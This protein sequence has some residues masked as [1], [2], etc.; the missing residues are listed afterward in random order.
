MSKWGDPCTHQ[1]TEPVFTYGG[2]KIGIM[3]RSCHQILKASGICVG[4]GKTSEDVRI[5]KGQTYC[6]DECVRQKRSEER[7]ERK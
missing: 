6:G 4:C 7:A 1:K 2:K 3:C 5:Y